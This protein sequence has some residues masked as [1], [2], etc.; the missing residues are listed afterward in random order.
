MNT[1]LALILVLTLGACS[2]D[3]SSDPGGDD[4]GGGGSGS[5]GGGGGGGGGGSNRGPLDVTGSYGLHST[6]DL[7]ANMPGTAGT[8]VNTIIAATEGSDNPT[9]W[10]VNQL[11]A[12][13][14]DGTVRT[15]INFV[16]E[17]VI[18]YLDSKVDQFAP[19]FVTKMLLVGQ[20]FGTIAK[21]FGLNETL[22]LTGSGT[23][24]T[25]VHTVTGVRWKI[26]DQ[27][28]DYGFVNYRLPNVVASDVA[29]TMDATG[30]LTVSAHD[31]PLAYGQL[32]RLGLDAAIIP[33][34]DSKAHNLNELLAHEI[35]CTAVGNFVAD[36]I[37][38]G[39][40]A[41]TI[42]SACT[43]G[44]TAGANYVYSKITAI[45]GSALSFGLT[46]TARAQDTNND[47]KIDAIQSGSWS[48]TLR[49]GAT[50]APLAPAE[51]YGE[52]M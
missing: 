46:G 37:G 38:L 7:A 21:R 52:R 41:S 47:R 17:P 4:G 14:P 20:D 9:R 25:A 5:G 44:I 50:P 32:L 43:A 40:A 22:A 16:K 36:K 35:D 1:R 51:F 15:A 23:S 26:G 39:F 11:I 45:D 3:P 33:A 42:K 24:Y 10:I 19:D 18:A 8:V 13:L 30:Q 2:S 27:E 48:G 28:G 12:Q 29:V 34:I 31:L 6:F 49:Y